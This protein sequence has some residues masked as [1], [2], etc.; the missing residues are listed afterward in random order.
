MK[1]CKKALCALLTL[2]LLLGFTVPAFAAAKS[3]TDVKPAD[4]HYVPVMQAA[5]LG[6]INGYEDGQFK[7]NETITRAQMMQIL[8][9]YYGEDN[10]TASGFSDVP[11]TA[12]FAK[13]VTWAVNKGLITPASADS[14]APNAPLAREAMVYSLYA[15][16]GAPAADQAA[17]N[18]FTDKNSISDYAKDAFAWTI[19]NQIVSGMSAT[20]L[21]PNGNATRAQVAVIMTRYLEKTDVPLPNIEVVDTD[22]AVLR[23]DFLDVVNTFIYQY[24]F[25]RTD[26]VSGEDLVKL[27]WSRSPALRDPKWLTNPEA[28]ADLVNY[29]WEMSPEE[30]NT[31]W[32]TNPKAEAYTIL[33]A[34]EVY[35]T[36]YTKQKRNADA[37]YS[38]PNG[39]SLIAMENIL[40]WSEDC[41]AREVVGVWEISQACKDVMWECVTNKAQ[42]CAAEYKGV[43]VLTAWNEQS[44]AILQSF[45]TKGYPNTANNQLIHGDAFTLDDVTDAAAVNS[46]HDVGKDA[47]YPTIGSTT[48]PNA[49]GYYTEANVYVADSKLRY[50]LLDELNKYLTSEGLGTAT[51]VTLDEA[52]EYT[53]MRAHEADLVWH[54]DGVKDLSHDQQR[55]LVHARIDGSPVV[56]P[57]NLRMDGRIEDAHNVMNGW[58]NSDGH[59]GLLR[60]TP[61]HQV[62]FASSGNVCVMTAW[63][64]ELYQGGVRFAPF[65][66]FFHYENGELMGG[67][68]K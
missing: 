27:Y 53:L 65:D 1:K 22:G 23:H 26:R 66:Y 24:S 3:F 32:V 35:D 10:G 39:G 16:E 56:A 2:A 4:W 55:E 19:S 12:W 30:R 41:P 6:L 62:C 43:F 54:M 59:R 68:Q 64:D 57:E 45:G 18:T 46:I 14:F 5:E 33:R 7:P 49:N 61:N 48:K 36:Y 13:A 37:L 9:N 44:L 40:V 34:K 17:L 8:Y 51:W 21:A 38:R 52:E 63:T 60:A 67:P 20:E 50:D 15:L 29:Y 42:I 47:E 11:E 28:G 58:I 25:N 31:T